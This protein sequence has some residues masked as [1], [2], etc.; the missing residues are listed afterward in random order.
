MTD[1]NPNLN[2]PSKILR[3]RD[4]IE[5]CSLSRSSIYAFMQTNKF[6]K[7][8]RLG[9]RAVGWLESEIESFLT[10]RAEQ[11]GGK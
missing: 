3:L 7:P 11:R 6:P 1:K 5:R 4:V 8:I 2:L 9:V 10:E